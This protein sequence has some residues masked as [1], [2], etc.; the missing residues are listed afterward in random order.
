MNNKQFGNKLAQGTR[1]FAVRSI[2]LS[3]KLRNTPEARVIRNQIPKSGGK[4]YNQEWAFLNE[5]LFFLDF[6]FSHFSSL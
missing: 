1:K 4:R 2:S 3:T 5:L 6:N